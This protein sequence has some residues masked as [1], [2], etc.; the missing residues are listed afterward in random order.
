VEVFRS[1]AYRHHDLTQPARTD[2]AGHPA[3]LPDHLMV[4][5]P[6]SFDFAR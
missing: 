1:A 6:A 3:D 2:R 4:G 5:Q